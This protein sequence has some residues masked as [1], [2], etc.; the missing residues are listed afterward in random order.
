[1]LRGGPGRLVQNKHLQICSHIR[2]SRNFEILYLDVQILSDCCK[3][4]LR[5]SITRCMANF[6]PKYGELRPTEPEPGRCALPPRA[7]ESCQCPYRPRYVWSLQVDFLG[8]KYR[9]DLHRMRPLERV[10]VVLNH[11]VPVQPCV[12]TDYHTRSDCVASFLS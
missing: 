3:F 7:A 10:G 4:S 12:L 6:T 8:A 2:R 11:R 1:M 5:R 9:L